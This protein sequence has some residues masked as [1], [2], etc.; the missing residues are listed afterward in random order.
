[1]QGKY[2]TSA[3]NS[4]TVCKLS[5]PWRNSKKSKGMSWW[6]WI[7]CQGSVETLFTPTQIGN[8]WTSSSFQKSCDSGRG[9]TPSTAVTERDPEPVN[10][11]RDRTTKLYQ[12]RPQE[13]KMKWCVYCDD[14]NHK[15]T[16]CTKVKSANERK[17]ILIKQRLCL[18]CS[19]ASH[20]ASD[21][22]SKMKCLN[23]EH[24]EEEKKVI[25]TA[26]GNGEGV[27]PAVIVEVDGI[28]WW[29]LLDS[30]AGSSYASTK[31]IN[32]LHK[33]PHAIK[34]K[35]VDIMMSLHVTKII[36]K[37]KFKFKIKINTIWCPGSTSW[38]FL[39]SGIPHIPHCTFA[40]SCNC[41]AKSPCIV[42]PSLTLFQLGSESSFALAVTIA[43]AQHNSSSFL[44]V[45]NISSSVMLLW[46]F[47]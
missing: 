35:H 29:A 6:C 34:T 19:G 25:L 47:S 40:F 11:D 16:E 42:L 21:C 37:I 24:T 7:S 2:T 27:F 5:R 18:N 46:P 3:T 20:R 30:G 10:R 13:F 32:L 43:L 36:I 4:C 45:K 39:I 28:T 31:P 44:M 17:Q 41:V 14:V 22:P 15:S 23:C 38:N 1:M 9:E 8:H 33:K 26:S 12:A